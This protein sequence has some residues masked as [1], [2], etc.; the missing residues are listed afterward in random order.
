MKD[1]KTLSLGVNLETLIK[2]SKPEMKILFLHRLGE[3]IW[4][5]EAEPFYHHEIYQQWKRQY[6]PRYM[7]DNIKLGLKNWQ[8]TVATWLDDEFDLFLKNTLLQLFKTILGPSNENWVNFLIDDFYGPNRYALTELKQELISEISD[9][10]FLIH[11][12][13]SLKI[14][15]NLIIS[16][17]SNLY[18][19]NDGISQFKYC[20]LS[21]ENLIPRNSREISDAEVPLFLKEIFKR[22]T[23]AEIHIMITGTNKK[24]ITLEDHRVYKKG[25]FLSAVL[26]QPYFAC[27]ERFFASLDSKRGEPWINAISN[28]LKDELYSLKLNAIVNRI[29]TLIGQY[30]KYQHTL[31][32][33]KKLIFSIISPQLNENI[34]ISNDLN[35]N[36]DK[37][38]MQI[39][40]V[41][42][43]AINPSFSVGN[44][45][46]EMLSIN[47]TSLLYQQ[48]AISF[49]NKQ[50]SQYLINK[51]D[52]VFKPIYFPIDP[53]SI[54]RNVTTGWFIGVLGPNSVFPEINTQEEL[55]AAIKLSQQ[56]MVRFYKSLNV[57]FFK[58]KFSVKTLNNIKDKIVNDPALSLL[59]DEHTHTYPLNNIGR[60]TV[61][62]TLSIHGV[63]TSYVTGLRSYELLANRFELLKSQLI[64]SLPS[65]NDSLI[66]EW[67]RDVLNLEI[68]R[69]IKSGIPEDL[70]IAT[71]QFLANFVVLFFIEGVRNKA[72]FVSHAMM[73]EVVRH[74]L[75]PLKDALISG[76]PM[77][78]EGSTEP[79]RLLHAQVIKKRNVILGSKRKEEGKEIK[80]KPIRELRA[81]EQAVFNYY[82]QNHNYNSIVNI[83]ATFFRRSSMERLTLKQPAEENVSS[84]QL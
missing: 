28:E 31:T 57:D 52:A 15:N 2:N 60:V 47:E 37:I 71:K 76:F 35:R 67:L 73:L 58:P 45:L 72:A 51:R 82:Y 12:F 68:Q 50:L 24:I 30:Q 33:D 25:S 65:L 54:Q 1:D 75:I 7:P 62:Y 16:R 79:G 9:D 56:S 83:A 77:A 46:S 40:R 13:E 21:R 53:L 81:R 8:N 84:Y 66:A 78:P 42:Y 48:A 20:D 17:L 55:F 4:K 34:V 3:A 61:T 23:L 22:V 80:T 44:F 70:M 64:L 11:Q 6:L 32:L 41:I 29:N 5:G 43:H 27:S 10:R 69:L 59:G 14:F 49:A 74:N 18:V 38:E 39:R 19:F 26:S 36:Y 63:A